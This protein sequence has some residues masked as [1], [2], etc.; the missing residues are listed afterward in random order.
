MC[1]CWGG[2]YRDMSTGALLYAFKR[3]DPLCVVCICTRGVH[4]VYTCIDVLQVSLCLE[5]QFAH[6][7]SVTLLINKLAR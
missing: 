6:S 1:V 2:V 5:G 3:D 7:A 4:L